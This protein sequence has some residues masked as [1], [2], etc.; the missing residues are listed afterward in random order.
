[1][2]L[3]CRFANLSDQGF[4]C[5]SILNGSRKGHFHV[6]TGDRQKVHEFKAQVGQVLE[7]MHS[8]KKCL[9]TIYIFEA[10]KQ[11]AGLAVVDNRDDFNYIKEIHVFSVVA[12]FRH[13]GLGSI[14]LDHLLS[15][16]QSNVVYV[17]CTLQSDTMYRM[18]VKRGFEH[19][20]NTG[21]G[22]RV[23][24]KANLDIID[25]QP[26]RNPFM[27]AYPDPWLDMDKTVLDRQLSLGGYS[28]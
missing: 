1:M 22:Y 10:D 11:R 5:S 6:D 27:N 25:A 19:I 18:L 16:M 3:T 2:K 24:K 4:I 14:M 15:N 9:R 7:L 23:L 21:G 20:R 8:G 28:R 13:R 17:R 12:E 26:Q